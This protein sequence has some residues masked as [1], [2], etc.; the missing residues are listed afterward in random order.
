M[1][2]EVNG[3]VRH[4]RFASPTPTELAAATGFHLPGR[5]H[6]IIHASLPADSEEN[7][8]VQFRDM[9]FHAIHSISP[10][11]FS[12]TSHHHKIYYFSLRYQNLTS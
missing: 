7:R 2:L 9:T 3:G 1:L 10:T 11:L 8:H 4:N 5:H 6:G 12:H